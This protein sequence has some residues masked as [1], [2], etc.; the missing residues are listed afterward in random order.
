MG[1]SEGFTQGQLSANGEYAIAH[2][3]RLSGKK[4]RRLTRKRVL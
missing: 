4:S 2:F 3:L 1:E